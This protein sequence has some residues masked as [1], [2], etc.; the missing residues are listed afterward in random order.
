VAFVWE[1]SGYVETTQ[2]APMFVGVVSSTTTMIVVSLLTQ[3]IAPVPEHIA[4]VMDEAATVGPIPAGMQ[5][6]ADVTL[7]PEAAAIDNAT[8]EAR[9]DD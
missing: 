7:G 5:A 6:G 8:R 3:K 1:N 2:L 9:R 4:R